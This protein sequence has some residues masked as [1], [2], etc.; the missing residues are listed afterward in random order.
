MSKSRSV[1]PSARDAKVPSHH[2][3]DEEFEKRFPSLFEFLALGIVDEEPRKG[4]SINLFCASGRLKVNFFDKHTQM[5]FFTDLK[6][7][8]PLLMEL[9]AILSGDHEGWQSAKKDVGKVPF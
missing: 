7:V 6:G 1:L 2:W 3:R 4:G 5:H 9:E 8:D